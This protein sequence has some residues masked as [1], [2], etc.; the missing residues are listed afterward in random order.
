MTALEPT[1]RRAPILASLS[2]EKI[3][4][5][6]RTSE[7]KKYPKRAVIFTANEPN[8]R[9]YLLQSGRVKLVRASHSGRELILDLISPL[10]WFGE[11]CLLRATPHYGVTAEVLEEAVVVSFKRAELAGAVDHCGAALKDYALLMERRQAERSDR[12][13]ELV[14]YDVPTRIARLLYKLAGSQSRHA[15]G[16]TMI[17]LKLTHQDIANMVGST[18][19]TTTLVLNDFR[20]RGVIDF[21]GRRI[22]V[23]DQDLLSSII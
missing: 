17:R 3:Q 1:M 16:G 8:E 10:E 19:E 14:F 4:E 13:A 15:R 11:P 7:E 12:L 23:C 18:R 9:V 2:E 5:I 6:E 21:A 20:R 22:V